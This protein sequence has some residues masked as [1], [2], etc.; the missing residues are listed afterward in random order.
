MHILFLDQFREPGG[1]QQCLR[2]LLPAVT[3]RGWTYDLVDNLQIG[4][5]NSGRK[6]LRDAFLFARQFPALFRAIRNLPGDLLYVNGPRL[7][8]AVPSGRPVVFHCHNFLGHGYDA[9]LARNAIRRTHATVVG[10]CRFVLE[11]LRVSHPHVVYNGVAAAPAKPPRS[12]RE[13]FH[14]GMIG[15]IAREKGQAEF[16]RAARELPDCRF[17]ICGAPLFG[18]G[19]YEREIRSQAQRLPVE[20]L[21]WQQNP[22]AVLA[23]LDLLVVPSTVPEAAPRVILEAF[24]AGVPVLAA[25]TGGIPELIQHR[26]TGFLIET[27][28]AL[29][30]Q[31]RELA[32][33]PELLSEVA[34]NAR[35]EWRA[36]FTLEEYQRRILNIV[37]IAGSSAR[38]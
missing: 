32:A 1:A 15:R 10:A 8:P 38:K 35:A 25:A 6:S 33:K 20:F 30:R 16:L 9:W 27:E 12:P 23:R 22:G 37:E 31:I 4:P 34:A 24:S 3:A 11:P 5:F 19:A 29:A 14:A 2:D 13:Q 28:R 36:R 21:G 17:T 18:N 7:L 26:R